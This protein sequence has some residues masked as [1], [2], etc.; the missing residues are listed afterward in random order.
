MTSNDIREK[1]LKFFEQKGHTRVP[2]SS[3]LPDDPSVLLTTAG[4]QQFKP[5][6]TGQA[7][8]IKDFGSKNT[9][10]SQ[11]CFRTSDIDEV[12]D[13]RHLTFFEMLGN[14]SFGGYFKKEA[15]KYASDFIKELGLEIDY[16]TIFSPEKIEASDWRKNVPE[17]LQ[18]Y[19]IWKEIGV[20]ENK[21]RKEGIDNFWGPTGNEGPC[22]PTTEIYVKPSPDVEAIEIWNIVF[23]EYYCHSDKHLEKLPTPGID[24]GMGL[25]RLAMVVQKVPTVFDTDL[26]I[27]LIK[28]L[29]D[30]LDAK[31][32]R[33]FADHS[34]A[35]CFLISDDIT[36]SN[37]EAGYVLRRLMRKIISQEE[38]RSL[39][40]E[41]IDS[42]IDK[43]IENYHSAYPKLI[44][45]KN[46]IFEEMNTERKKFSDVLK[47]TR[48]FIMSGKI[49]LD[50][51]ETNS[52]RLTFKSFYL[53]QDIV[54]LIFDAYQSYGSP[55]EITIELIQKGKLYGAADSISL[56]QPEELEGIKKMLEKKFIHHQEISRAGVEKKFGGHGLKLDTG[57]IKA[58]SEEEI[59]K[60]TRLHTATHLLHAG[61]RKVLGN[62]IQQRGSDITSERLRFDFTFDRKLT[63]EEKAAVEK[64]VNDAV[65]ADVE[66]IHKEMPYDEAIVS[67]FLAFF[68]G[69]YPAVVSTYELPGWSKEVCGGPHVSHSGEIGKFKIIKDEA[70][71]AG[72]RRIRAIVE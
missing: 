34:R 52:N 18:S 42:V 3:L 17:D 33:I 48:A 71:S 57:E 11:K 68:R 63:A 53:K 51:S 15:I 22:G 26:L 14:F 47:K 55:P 27:P 1:F 16:V 66:M 45:A 67:G 8:P 2:S 7:D 38:L 50:P 39:N 9:T 36:P 10:S 32:K 49:A 21:I 13:E 28:I 20:P 5:Y 46:K 58:A 29:P 4:M 40:K 19:E 30:K 44:D 54:D 43:V 25:E 35:I 23:N 56:D 61:L 37:K 24:T 6:F 41:V 72:V 31:T 64:Y 60:V 69:K 12:G 65:A 70:S 62:T 59:K